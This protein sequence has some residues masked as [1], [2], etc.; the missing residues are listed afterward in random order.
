[1][2]AQS[3]TLS[4]GDLPWSGPLIGLSRR[5]DAITYPNLSR[6]VAVVAHNAVHNG[7]SML[8]VMHAR[9]ALR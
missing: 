9:N 2:H 1:M 3:D 4:D 6:F 5:H 7:A 8:E